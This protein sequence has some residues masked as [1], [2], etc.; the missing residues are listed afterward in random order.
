MYLLLIVF[1]VISLLRGLKKGL[2]RA[3]VNLIVT[4]SS[5]V[6]AFL[7]VKTISP[8]FTGLVKDLLGKLEDKQTL[9]TTKLQWK[10]MKWKFATP[11]MRR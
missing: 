4:V 1:V 7:M 9:L 11:T 2:A 8:L 6:V 5:T 3:I 10:S